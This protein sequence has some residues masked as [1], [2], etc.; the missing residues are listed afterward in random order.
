M[1][2]FLYK[3]VNAFFHVKLGKSEMDSCQIQF[4][5]LFKRTNNL[6]FANSMS[7]A[8]DRHLNKGS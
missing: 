4:L 5:F 2:G 8:L 7:S 6:I 3:E 1:I